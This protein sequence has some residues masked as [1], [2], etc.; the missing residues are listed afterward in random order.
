MVAYYRKYHR[1]TNWAAYHTNK[2]NQL[3]SLFAGIDQ[4]IESIFLNLDKNA[5]ESIFRQYGRDYGDDA[6]KYARKT[7]PKWKN[8]TTKLSGQT[9]ERL[10]NLLPPFLSQNKRYE[11]VKK[12]RDYYMN[13]RQSME[14]V[15]TSPEL[16]K[17]D[18]RPVV[19]RIVEKSSKFKL[20]EEL[21]RR[22]AWLSGGDV[23][24]ANKILTSVE[25]E[26]AKLRTAY[27]DVEFRRID[28]YVNIVGNTQAV[29]H[30]I[31][32]PQGTIHVTI[33]QKKKPFINIVFG[34]GKMNKD[35]RE[36]VPKEEMERALVKQ[37]SRG[38]LL[39]L[40]FDDLNEKQK[41]ALR[42]RVLNERLNLEISHHKADQRF[43]NSTRDM[44]NTIKAVNALEQASKSDY[45]IK[46]SYE[47]ASGSTNITVKKNNNTVI[48]V[49]AI[50]IGIIIF[51]FLKR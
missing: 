11:L 41:N 46:S 13:K 1:Q 5:L 34:G 38:E 50:V 32:L 37:Q 12:I 22:A 51:F 42:E 30:T 10:L 35:S 33:Q 26:E 48:I 8:G 7:F 2:R 40:S 28:Q 36:L 6:E 45:E 25:Q 18:L 44:A 29:T 24:S 20:P 17:Q 31:T 43:A 27:L 19:N 23:D 9:A 47:T 21:K 49:I 4:D 3:T 15:T 39:N 16:W 14:H